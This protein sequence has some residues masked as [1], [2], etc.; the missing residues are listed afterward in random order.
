MAI[1]WKDADGCAGG[2]ERELIQCVS[3]FEG[4]CTKGCLRWMVPPPHA[5]ADADTHTHTHTQL[6]LSVTFWMC[7]GAEPHTCPVLSV[8][9]LWELELS[10]RYQPLHMQIRSSSL[11]CG[12]TCPHLWS[13]PFSPSVRATSFHPSINPNL[14]LNRF[15]PLY[16][17]PST[18][19]P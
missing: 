3:S 8:C 18:Q 7:H 10:R 14:S 4:C 11:W 5:H 6:S 9:Q 13:P 1:R 19:A 17:L 2:K 15:P 12:F 16:H